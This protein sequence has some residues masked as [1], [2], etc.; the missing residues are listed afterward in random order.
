MKYHD[1]FKCYVSC[2]NY[3]FS[4]SYNPNPNPPNK[5]SIIPALDTPRLFIRVE[6]GQ[7]QNNVGAMVTI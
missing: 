2:Y 1:H 3:E 4:S 7:L 6:L 5:Q